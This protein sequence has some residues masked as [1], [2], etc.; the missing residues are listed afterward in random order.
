MPSKTIA[1]ELIALLRRAILPVL[2]ELNK[3]IFIARCKRREKR[4]L[5]RVAEFA[6]STR[7]DDQT[8]KLA[9]AENH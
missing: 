7:Q 5:A 9:L 6:N 2:N 8:D 4:K 1:T 3:M